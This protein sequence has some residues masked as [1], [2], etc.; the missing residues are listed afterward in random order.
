M[1]PKTFIARCSEFFGKKPGQTLQDFK[2]E[3]DALTPQD[4]AD[5]IEMFNVAG[6][7]TKAA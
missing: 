4:K 3:I 6:M 1:E 7:P 2:K 5:M